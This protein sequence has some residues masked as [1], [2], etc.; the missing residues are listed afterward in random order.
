VP[1]PEELIRQ[2][3]LFSS[4]DKKEVQGLAS[5]MKER[6]FQ[7]GDTIAT[8]GQSGIGFFIIDE[9]EAAVSVGGDERATLGHGDYFGEIALIDDGARTA[10]ITAKSPLKC[11]GITSWEFR[12]LVEQNA[13]LAWKMLKTLAARLRE[14]EQRLG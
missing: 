10:T 11:Y 14:A 9:G 13:G 7:A 2:V 5:S 3:P 4:L 8:E 12:P 6:T 1:A